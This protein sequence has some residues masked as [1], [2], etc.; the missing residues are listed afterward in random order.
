MRIKYEDGVPIIML[1]ALEDAWRN[2][3]NKGCDDYLIKPYESED[4]L[5]KIKEKLHERK[6]LFKK[7]E[8]KL[9]E[10]RLNEIN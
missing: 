7:I 4:L 2:S 8:E 10:R 3:F 5:K 1:T 9:E 6:D